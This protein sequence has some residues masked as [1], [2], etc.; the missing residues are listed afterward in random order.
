M[1]TASGVRKMDGKV[2]VVHGEDALNAPVQRGLELFLSPRSNPGHEQGRQGVELGLQFLASCL[3]SQRVI[4]AGY[5]F[6]T[7][8]LSRRRG[9]G[10]IKWTPKFS[11]RAVGTENMLG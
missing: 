2:A 4:V 7:G 8:D 9:P 11:G 10:W 1:L 3:E 5:T 6:I